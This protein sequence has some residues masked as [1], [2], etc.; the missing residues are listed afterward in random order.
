[1]FALLMT[2]Y[3][4]KLAIIQIQLWKWGYKC[5]LIFALVQFTTILHFTFIFLRY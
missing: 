3:E 4:I 1:M 2:R 5:S